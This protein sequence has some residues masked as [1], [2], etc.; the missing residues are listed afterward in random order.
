MAGGDGGGGQLILNV[1]KVFQTTLLAWID[2]SQ[3]CTRKPRNWKFIFGWM[4]CPRKWLTCLT[5]L[6]NEKFG[7]LLHKE[8]KRK[9]V[10]G[11]TAKNFVEWHTNFWLH[12]V[13]VS[14][15]EHTS[16]SR[17]KG[18][19]VEKSPETPSYLAEEITAH[20]KSQCSWLPSCF[21]KHS[22]F[23][24]FVWFSDIFNVFSNHWKCDFDLSIKTIQPSNVGCHISSWE[25]RESSIQA[26]RF[27]V[28]L[29]FRP[30][31]WSPN[32]DVVKIWFQI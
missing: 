6:P 8:T 16:L 1:I 23:P 12:K 25:T 30:A 2:S 4:S 18:A 21:S 31:K 14:W 5:M 13:Q 15:V 9:L 17:F 27:C 22:W 11:T 19:L 3:N 20:Y 32:I 7:L 29:L 10:Q 26:N 28:T 24:A